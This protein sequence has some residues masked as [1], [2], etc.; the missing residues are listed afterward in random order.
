MGRLSSSFCNFVCSSLQ[1]RPGKHY[2]LGGLRRAVG[3]YVRARSTTLYLLPVPSEKR[4]LAIFSSLKS[5]AVALVERQWYFRPSILLTAP[6]Q[7][8]RPQVAWSG[9]EAIVLVKVR[10]WLRWRSPEQTRASCYFANVTNTFDACKRNA[11]HTSASKEQ[12]LT[13][14]FGTVLLQASKEK[15]ASSKAP[16]TTGHTAE[17]QRGLVV[18]ALDGATGAAIF[19]TGPSRWAALLRDEPG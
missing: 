19:S 1:T 8:Q 13:N 18:W 7:I 4:K 14:I 16:Q 15:E 10:C 12:T 2:R 11:V 3:V 5:Q 17:I 6:T 9:E